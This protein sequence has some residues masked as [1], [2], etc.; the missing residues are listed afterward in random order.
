MKR[1]LIF[2]GLKIAEIVGAGIAFFLLHLLMTLLPPEL[3]S[4]LIE[5][6]D[7]LFPG[8]DLFWCGIISM[9]I[10]LIA[11]LIIIVLWI[12]ENWRWAKVLSKGIYLTSL[13]KFKKMA[14]TEDPFNLFEPKLWNDKIGDGL[15]HCAL[16]SVGGVI[17][18]T[19]GETM[20]VA[21][22]RCYEKV[23]EWD[24]GLED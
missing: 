16:C 21:I 8:M 11:M 17:V 10:A 3:M 9:I 20:E 1:I 12:R 6:M 22:D 18:E 23:A 15:W 24:E 4:K 14:S 13:E 19:T 7:S 2:L 5:W